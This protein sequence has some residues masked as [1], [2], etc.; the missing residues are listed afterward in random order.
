MSKSEITK[1]LLRFQQTLPMADISKCIEKFEVEIS[2]SGD[3]HYKLELTIAKAHYHSAGGQKELAIK[4]LQDCLVDDP[5]CISVNYFLGEYLVE[6]GRFVEAQRFLEVAI[7]LSADINDVWFIE[8]AYLLA[9]YCAVLV[10]K[11]DVARSYLSFVQDDE[12]IT[13]L[14]VSSVISKD[15]VGQLVDKL[16]RTQDH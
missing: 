12:S 11:V 10:K 8:S 14:S 16:Q 13:W 15:S 3:H 4:V 5:S 1:R 2:S 9:A 7:Q 6:A